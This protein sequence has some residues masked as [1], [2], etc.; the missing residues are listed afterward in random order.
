M[1]NYHGE[2]REKKSKES[3]GGTNG[4]KR[5]QSQEEK[6][7]CCNAGEIDKEQRR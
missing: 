7:M 2:E 5:T 6:S 1:L 3:V 4:N